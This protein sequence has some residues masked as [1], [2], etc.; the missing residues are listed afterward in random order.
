MT[1]LLE[2]AFKEASKLPGTEQNAFAKRLLE[3]LISEKRWGKLFANS[4]DI[5]SEL[6]DEAIKEHRQGKTKLLNISR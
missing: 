2:K 1:K 4:E 5:L 6:A 3:E